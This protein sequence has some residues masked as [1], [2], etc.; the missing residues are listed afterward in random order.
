MTGR[1]PVTRVRSGRRTGRGMARL[2]ADF[3]HDLPDSDPGAASG[4]GAADVPAYG[5][6]R[7]RGGRVGAGRR[8]IRR[9]CRGG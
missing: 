9:W 7:A 3:G 8:R 4:P 1:P 6:P 5:G 2:L